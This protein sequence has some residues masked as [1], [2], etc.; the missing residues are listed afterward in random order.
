[1]LG[2]IIIA[3]LVGIV[4]FVLWN[5]SKSKKQFQQIYH[6]I[7]SLNRKELKVIVDDLLHSLPLGHD[8][9]GRVDAEIRAKYGCVT[10]AD[11]SLLYDAAVEK[12]NAL[13]EKDR[14]ALARKRQNNME[15]LTDSEKQSLKRL[16]HLDVTETAYKKALQGDVQAMLFMGMT[17]NLDLK[18]PK[19]AFYWMQKADAA[20]DLQ[21]KYFL[22]TYY[23]D[24]YGVE[25]NKTK[26]VSLILT[27]AKKG[28]VDAV[29]FCV[30]KLHMSKEEMQNV[31]ISV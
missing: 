29:N 25:K 10:R 28:N 6:S 17:Y 3:I 31:G 23:G 15:S 11:A 19:K 8:P 16:E 13:L 5:K 26:G 2:F 27:A 18:N 20:G 12:Y 14:T 24:G 9:S 30:E 4:V 1:M 7:D 22:G 21:A